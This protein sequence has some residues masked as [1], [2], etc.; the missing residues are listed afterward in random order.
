ME[1]LGYIKRGLENPRLGWRAGKALLRGR[2][3]RI[4]FKLQGRRVIIG[5][6]FQV[7]GP[8]IIKGPGTVIFGDDC[9]VV[10]SRLYPTTPFTHSPD[11]VLK[12]GDRVKL[13]ST[14][15]GCAKRIEVEDDA[16]IS[17]A[18][19]IDTDFHA[20]EV[21]DT[22]RANTPGR[23]KAIR[24]GRNAWIGAGVM[25]LKG[26][27]IGENSVVGAG[28]VVM[29]SVPANA[30]VAGNPARV[31]WRLKGPSSESPEQAPETDS[32]P[33]SKSQS[34]PSTV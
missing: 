28:S 5:R 27:K 22:H 16:G 9:A 14:R 32:Q 20:L 19:I 7:T 24:I 10:S 26:V 21:Y 30:V 13:A 8:L 34:E 31:V 4:K 17:D 1:W 23:S 6:R 25:I 3:Y 15:F 11:A 18:R 33:R 12:F 29:Y 2:Y